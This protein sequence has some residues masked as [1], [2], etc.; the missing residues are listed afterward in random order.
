MI[1][2]LPWLFLSGAYLLAWVLDRRPRVR[3]SRPDIKGLWIM[4]LGL[5]AAPLALAGGAFTGECYLAAG[6]YDR[7]NYAFVQAVGPRSAA[8]ARRLSDQG[9]QAQTMLRKLQLQQRFPGL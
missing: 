4:G 2:F 5:A 1:F 7:A 6:D 3:L 9:E 8:P